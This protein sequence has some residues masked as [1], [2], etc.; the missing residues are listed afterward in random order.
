M[1]KKKKKKPCVC[2]CISDFT[3]M[4]EE[5]GRKQTIFGVFSFDS[6]LKKKGKMSNKMNNPS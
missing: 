1:Q 3:G 5:N 2:A 4:K 6:Y